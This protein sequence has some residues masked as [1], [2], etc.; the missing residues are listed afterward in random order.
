[1]TFPTEHDWHI[2]CSTLGRLLRRLFFVFGLVSVICFESIWSRMGS[3]KY[4]LLRFKQAQ[5]KE[6]PVSSNSNI[7]GAQ[8]FL[9]KVHNW[10]SKCVLPLTWEESTKSVPSSEQVEFRIISDQMVPANK[11]SPQK[12]PTHQDI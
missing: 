11:I 1:M 10:Q 2:A 8:P 7:L 12:I 5:Q 9:H 3:S 4:T 6:G